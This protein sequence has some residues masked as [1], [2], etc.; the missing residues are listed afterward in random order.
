MKVIQV[1][2]DLG[3]YKGFPDDTGVTIALWKLRELLEH[4]HPPTIPGQ[5]DHL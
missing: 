5:D 1:D 3:D 2:L 4:Y